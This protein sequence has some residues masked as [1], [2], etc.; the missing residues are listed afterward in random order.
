MIGRRTTPL[1]A[2]VVLAASA[3]IAQAQNDPRTWS[4]FNGDLE[5]PEIF[6]RRPRSRR[7]TSAS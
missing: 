2:L 7:Q 5:G 6:D 3:G 1:A 4:T